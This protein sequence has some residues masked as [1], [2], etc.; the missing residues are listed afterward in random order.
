MNEKLLREILKELK[1]IHFHLNN[2]ETLYKFVNRVEMKKEM[3]K[4][5]VKKEIPKDKK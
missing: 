4:E 3:K 2:L 5:E 1:N